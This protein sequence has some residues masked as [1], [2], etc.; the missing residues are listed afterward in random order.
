MHILRKVVL[1]ATVGLLAAAP[2]VAQEAQGRAWMT[3]DNITVEDINT[4]VEGGF[5][6]Y[7]PDRHLRG[8][9]GVELTHASDT[10]GATTVQQVAYTQLPDLPVIGLQ[11]LADG[12]GQASARIDGVAVES[13]CGLLTIN[14]LC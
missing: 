2:A 8:L 14:R 5:R 13:G 10:T 11:S 7:N 3:V 9:T 1:A 4:G 6:W 12:T